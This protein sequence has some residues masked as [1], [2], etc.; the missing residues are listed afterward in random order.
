MKDNGD[1][2]TA[3]G[4]RVMAGLLAASWWLPATWL[5]FPGS[6]AGRSGQW[7]LA[8]QLTRDANR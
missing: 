5:A 7:C 8:R 3:V 1:V 2:K 6:T 4:L